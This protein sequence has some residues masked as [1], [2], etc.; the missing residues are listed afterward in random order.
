MEEAQSLFRAFGGDA[1][2]EVQ[3]KKQPVAVKSAATAFAGELIMKACK[4]PGVL[5]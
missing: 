2:S 5:P 3:W 4:R 1:A